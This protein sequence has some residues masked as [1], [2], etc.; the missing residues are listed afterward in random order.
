MKKIFQR[1][2]NSFSVYTKVSF[3]KRVINLEEQNL[4]AKTENKLYPAMP[5][6]FDFIAYFDDNELESIK[7]DSVDGLPPIEANTAIFRMHDLECTETNHLTQS[8]H[9]ESCIN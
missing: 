5:K 7:N 6:T 1:I 3:F 2:I 9:F 8:H 4:K